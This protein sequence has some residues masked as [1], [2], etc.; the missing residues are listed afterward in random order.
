MGNRLRGDL[1]RYL[2]GLAVPIVAGTAATMIFSRVFSPEELGTYLLVVA[3]TYSIGFPC[4]VWLYQGVLRFYPGHAQRG[5]ERPFLRAMA[6]LALLS[7]VTA[8]LIVVA[9]LSLGLAGVVPDGRLLLPAAV[10]TLC[11]SA[12]GWLQALLQAQFAVNRYSAYNAACAIARLGLP[13]LFLPVVGG[14]AALLWGTAAVT[15]A[16]WVTLCLLTVTT[17]RQLERAG[18]LPGRAAGDLRSIGGELARFGLPLTAFELAAQALTYSDRYVIAV[19]LGTGA[20]GLYSTNYSIAEK[21]LIL[22]QAPL[23]QAV[24]VHVVSAW[25][26]GDA[27]AAEQLIRTATRWLLLAGLP[28][29]AIT[30]VRSE[31]ISGL[32]LGE[33]FV[34][35]HRV[36]PITTFAVLVW[37]TSQY[38]HKCFELAK[39]TWV[40]TGAL[41]AAAIVNVGGA[42]VLT[43]GIGYLGGALATAL[44]FGV[45]GVII[46]VASRVI[47]AF[48]WRLPWRTAGVAALGAVG[49][50]AVW[51]VSVP[52]RITSPLDL[53]VAMGGGMAG[54]L[55]YGLIVSRLGELPPV[56]LAV[57][58]VRFALAN[59]PVQGGTAS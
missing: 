53:I 39:N 56:T 31:L 44:G 50:S 6:V 23:I 40:M 17:T 36:L 10:M 47:G 22:V 4:T 55:V 32:L 11:T 52:T 20:V 28:L 19:L 34:A 49:A 59:R 35:G 5:T 30:A 46:F 38:G 51:S 1:L 43:N 8:T 7:A 57:D 37:A 41:V 45:Y 58:Q 42:I 15:L 2:P 33:A 14:V 3:L 48:P 25:E 9:M 54:L 26:R 13:L 16:G 24:H 27:P 21:L 18:P 29:V 12:S